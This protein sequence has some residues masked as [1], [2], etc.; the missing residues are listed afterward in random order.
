MRLLKAGKLMTV[1]EE[2][3]T[4]RKDKISMISMDKLKKGMNGVTI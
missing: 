4:N 2:R 3:L 1:R